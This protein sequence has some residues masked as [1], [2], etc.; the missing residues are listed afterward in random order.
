V[1]EAVRHLRT[2]GS[3]IRRLTTLGPEELMAEAKNL[4]APY[5]LVTLVAKDGKLPVPNFAAGG[6]ATPA[7][8]ALMMELGAESVFV[9]SGIFKSSD[10]TKRAKAIVKAVTHYKDAKLVAEVSRGLGEAMPGIEME[11]LS[12]SERLQTRGW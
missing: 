8:A 1:V 6:V 3:G 2:V 11:T 4:G 12:E 7:D 10:P 5:E 9:G